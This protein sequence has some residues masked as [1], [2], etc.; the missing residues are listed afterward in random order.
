MFKIWQ[1]LLRL[2]YGFMEYIEVKKNC[3]V[4]INEGSENTSIIMIP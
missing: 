4:H 2:I 1:F 3:A